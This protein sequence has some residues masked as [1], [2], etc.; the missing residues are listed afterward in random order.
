MVALLV[1]YSIGY[2]E[3]LEGRAYYAV[4]FSKFWLIYILFYL[5]N[6]LPM[7]CLT[8]KRSSLFC[9]KEMK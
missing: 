4:T 5:F 3:L 1:L 6:F 7:K 2:F 9:G 8:K